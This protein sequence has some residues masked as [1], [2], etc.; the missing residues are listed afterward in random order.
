[1]KQALLAGFSSLLLLGGCGDDPPVV[2]AAAG[3]A[4]GRPAAA[5]AP[6]APAGA[7]AAPAPDAAKQAPLPKVELVEAEFTESERSRDP[8]RS[9]LSIFK[10]ESKG[11]AKSQR[12]VVLAQFGIDELKLI[13]IVTRAE[14][15]KAML[16]DPAGTGHVVQRGQFVGR[17]DIV[18]AAGRTGAS[19]E[20]N[21]RVDRIRDG[22]IVL[23]REDPSNPDVPSATRVIPLR[24]EGS[25]VAGK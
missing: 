24:P 14:P 19:Y 20:I 13:G 25:E 1:M 23:I 4:G 7:P 3:G 18:Q 21:W 17:A 8:F 2:T 6:R 22:D 10:E 11:V 5:A 9:F 12:E 16:V 15:A